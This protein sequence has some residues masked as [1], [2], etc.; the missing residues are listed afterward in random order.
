M[1]LL[2]LEST[3]GPPAA[4]LSPSERK[5]I[6]FHF[7]SSPRSRHCRVKRTEFSIS[8]SLVRLV[9]RSSIHSFLTPTPS[10]HLDI[11]STSTSWKL[12]DPHHHQDLPDTRLSSTPYTSILPESGLLTCTSDY[13]PACLHILSLPGPCSR[14]QVGSLDKQSQTLPHASSHSRYH[15]LL[16]LYPFR[17]LL[18]TPLLLH[19]RRCRSFSSHSTPSDHRRS[20]AATLPQNIIFH[21]SATS[22]SQICLHPG[23]QRSVLNRKGI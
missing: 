13:I 8:F 5:H 21:L 18:R 19:H 7:V 23:W 20:L 10:S 11:T 17:E 9:C 22:S 2:R 14:A 1:L 6:P 12:V 3:W 4:T 16:H 15:T